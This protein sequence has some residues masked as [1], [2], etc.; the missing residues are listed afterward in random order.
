MNLADDNAT[1]AMSQTIKKEEDAAAAAAADASSTVVASDALEYILHQPTAAVPPAPAQQEDS[2]SSLDTNS[3][4][5]D[6]HELLKRDPTLSSLNPVK[7]DPDLALD[8]A[9]ALGVG[10]PIPQ[11]AGG[12]ANHRSPLNLPGQVTAG[13]A[14]DLDGGSG[15]GSSAPHGAFGGSSV[16]SNVTASPLLASPPPAGTPVFAATVSGA[17]GLQMQFQ[18]Q[19]QQQV[20]T[21]IPPHIQSI[22]HPVPIQSMDTTPPPN[23][24]VAGGGGVSGSLPTAAD[25]DL[26]LNLDSNDYFTNAASRNVSL[27]PQFTQ[28]QQK[29][30]RQQQQQQQSMAGSAPSFGGVAGTTIKTEPGLSPQQQ[31]VQMGVGMG[32]TSNTGAHFLQADDS[33]VFSTTSFSAQTG[34]A[35]FTTTSGGQAAIAAAAAAGVGGVKDPLSSSVP[36]SIFQNSPLSDILADLSPAGAG[37]GI[38]PNPPTSVSPNLPGSSPSHAGP[39]RHSTL[40]K[41]LL[42]KNKESAV[43]ATVTS[44]AAGG[45][46]PSPVRSPENRKTLDKMKS[47]LS[48]SNPLLCQQVR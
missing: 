19:Q 23:V 22:R 2:N 44:G 36:A 24:I 8:N 20:A 38:P 34:G 18:Q 30:L 40:Q 47:S 46:R 33:L 4:M 41:L 9:V 6:L 15:A 17:P 7:E 13:F 10:M 29:K 1:I 35:A 11:A 31:Q 39:E 37:A 48:A 28:Q 25:L 12:V 32:P 14:G 3:L 21:A 42:S 26:D 5:F 16:G 27:C 43:S 45:H